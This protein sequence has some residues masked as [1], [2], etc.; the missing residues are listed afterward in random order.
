MGKD[1]MKSYSDGSHCNVIVR[2]M[3]ERY[4]TYFRDYPPD[5]F[6]DCDWVVDKST[7]R[8]P[9]ETDQAYGQ[10]Q[11]DDEFAPPQMPLFAAQFCCGDRVVHASQDFAIVLAALLCPFLWDDCFDWKYKTPRDR[12][13]PVHI[14]PLLN[15]WCKLEHPQSKDSLS[16]RK[17]PSGVYPTAGQPW[18]PD[19]SISNQIP[20]AVAEA[21]QEPPAGEVGQWF[22]FGIEEHNG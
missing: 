6:L 10:Y 11:P 12:T 8:L 19:F 21:L 7:L 20:D 13:K 1:A 3:A 5:N 15:M 18:S 2:Q 9:K 17:M 22:D 16:S 4:S 14:A